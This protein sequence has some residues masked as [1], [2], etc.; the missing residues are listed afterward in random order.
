[1]AGRVWLSYVL[2][3]AVK[4]GAPMPD[5]AIVRANC[6]LIRLVEDGAERARTDTASLLRAMFG[7]GK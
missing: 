2:Y 3:L 5:D 6:A 7:G 1:M 4:A